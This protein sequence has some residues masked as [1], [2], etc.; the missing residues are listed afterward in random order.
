M[1]VRSKRDRDPRLFCGGSD[2]FGV[3]YTG[4]LWKVKSQGDI[5]SSRVDAAAVEIRGR[6]KILLNDIQYP[7]LIGPLLLLGLFKRFAPIRGKAIQGKPLSVED[8]TLLGEESRVL[9]HELRQCQALFQGV[10][11]DASKCTHVAERVHRIFLAT[12]CR[13]TWS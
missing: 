9:V 8:R 12:L 10:G 13:S 11:R 6:A 2:G 4:H 5:A 7:V 1:G 3:A